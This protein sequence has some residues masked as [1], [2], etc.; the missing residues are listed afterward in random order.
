MKMSRNLHVENLSEL[1]NFGERKTHHQHHC[2]HP[3][4]GNTDLHLLIVAAVAEAEAGSDLAVEHQKWIEEVV[5]MDGM[6]PYLQILGFAS[7]YK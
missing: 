6:R 3:N 7:S 1:G 2:N 5:G 4:F